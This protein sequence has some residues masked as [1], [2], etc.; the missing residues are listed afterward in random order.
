MIVTKPKFI[1]KLTIDKINYGHVSRIENY[2]KRNG[3][4]I[5]CGNDECGFY[6][7]CQKEFRDIELMQKEVQDIND[8]FNYKEV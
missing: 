6:L 3:W 5:G 7:S 4:E 1:V 2:M 8:A